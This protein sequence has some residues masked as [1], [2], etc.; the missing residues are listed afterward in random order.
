MTTT[1][2]ADILT[3]HALFAE[4]DE[5]DPSQILVKSNEGVIIATIYADEHVVSVRGQDGIPVG[6]GDLDA[7][8][9][10]IVGKFL[11]EEQAKA[12]Q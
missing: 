11:Q 9:S 4:P 7:A 10:W 3:V 12:N 1:N 5:D 8:Y 6:L 2:P